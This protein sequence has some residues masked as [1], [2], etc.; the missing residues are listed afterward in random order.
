M[1]CSCV[2]LLI[3][4]LVILLV[5]L[6]FVH[7]IMLSL[8]DEK[9][10]KRQ[11]QTWSGKLHRSLLTLQEKR[12]SE[13]KIDWSGQYK[14]HQH[15]DVSHYRESTSTI[16]NDDLTIVTQCS[17]NHLYHLI[18][19]SEEWEG[20]ISVA[21]FTTEDQIQ[22]A[23]S[24]ILILHECFQKIRTNVAFHLVYPFTFHEIN[25]NRQQILEMFD[26]PC[27]NI[28]QVLKNH[29]LLT[30]NY[31]FSGIAYP[32][33]LLRNVARVG[34]QSTF[35]FVID[36]DMIPS[37]HL[38]ADFLSFIQRTSSSGSITNN[39]A[40][41]VVPAFELFDSFN[42]IPTTKQEILDNFDDGVRPFY[43]EVCQKCQ[44]PTDYKNW[45]KIK[46]T[47][48]LNVAYS[49][50]WVDPWEPFYISSNDV[51]LYD[52]RFKQ[53]GFNRISQVCELHVAGYTFSVL[54]NAFVLHKGYKTKTGFHS[55]KDK[56]NLKNKYL[57]R[58]FKE[59]LLIKYPESSRRC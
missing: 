13:T 11:A 23:D 4:S 14:I 32:N 45:C 19:L 39:N 8:L 37:K 41:Y 38:R 53:Y 54:D 26:V 46:P 56:E 47:E 52:E 9:T 28:M 34:V 33:N 43:I 3:Y 7:W 16:A 55:N 27:K 20:P 40:V 58:Q 57:F 17:V 12:Q 48:G 6:Q 10:T 29:N 50:N 59:A 22:I 15:Y 35:I 31:D 24:A 25:E 36:I 5:V 21:V 30:Q 2:K 42:N 44:Y 18:E 1:R 51:P 49:R